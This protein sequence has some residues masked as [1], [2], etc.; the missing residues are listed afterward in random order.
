MITDT[1]ILPDTCPLGIVRIDD[2]AEPHRMQPYIATER[3]RFPHQIGT[4]LA[5]DTVLIV[6]RDFL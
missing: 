6:K 3:P 2:Q 4:P 1:L 5:K